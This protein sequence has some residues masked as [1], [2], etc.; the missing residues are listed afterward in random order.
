MALLG[1][2]RCAKSTL[3]GVLTKGVND[4]GN[5]YARNLM[6]NYDHEIKKGG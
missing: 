3:L 4:D 2:T 6:L 5:G 1:S